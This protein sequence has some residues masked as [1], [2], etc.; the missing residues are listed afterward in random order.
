LRDDDE[1]LSDDPAAVKTPIWRRHEVHSSGSAAE[2]AKLNG[3]RMVPQFDLVQLILEQR[4]AA[5]LAAA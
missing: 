3:R 1:L 5:K 2:D 4:A